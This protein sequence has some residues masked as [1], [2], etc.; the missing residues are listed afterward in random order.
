MW[1]RA[2]LNTG[3]KAKR[4]LVRLVRA[5]ASFFCMICFFQTVKAFH[6]LYRLKK[7]MAQILW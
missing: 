7:G 6:G 2:L 3:T 5:K 4:L 1:K